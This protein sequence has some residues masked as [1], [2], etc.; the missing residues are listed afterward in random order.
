[1]TDLADVVEEYHRAQSAIVRGDAGPLKRLYSR[2]PDATLANPLGPPARGWSQ[3]EAVLDHAV[4]LVREGEYHT[5]AVSE[6]STA[7]MAYIVEIERVRAKVVNSP[8]RPR[9]HCGRPPSS[10]VRKGPGRS[11]TATPI[12]S[13]PPA[14]SSPSSTTAHP[15]ILSDAGSLANCILSSA[16]RA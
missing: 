7:E 8:R 9:G 12:P 1:M 5:E 11:V 3:V 14:P 4:S 15:P 16:V 2:R 6:V 13:P 10:A